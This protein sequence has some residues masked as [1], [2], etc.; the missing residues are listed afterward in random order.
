[1]LH[2]EYLHW[3]KRK[4]IKWSV[5]VQSNNYESAKNLDVNFVVESLK[6]LPH[7]YA[8]F[9]MFSLVTGL[10]SSEAFKAFN[11][12]SN[13][14]NNH[15]ME[16][17]WDRRTKKANAVYCLPFLHDQI[18]FTISRKVYKF[19]NKRRI[20]FDLRHLRKVNFTVNV[21]SVDPLLAEFTQGRRGN[22]SQ[23]H[24][25]LPNMQSNFEKWLS[26]WNS[27]IMK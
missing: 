27:I 21:G 24:Y 18:N 23:R 26:V 4:E 6:K 15:V 25:F 10:R 11:N 22:V 8:I 5:P 2:D 1:S 3:L 19:I 17:F 20:G 9:G 16:L 13:L 14:C 12:H 7:R